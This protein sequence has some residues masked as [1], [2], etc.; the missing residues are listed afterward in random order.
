MVKYSIL[1]VRKVCFTKIGVFNEEL[2]RRNKEKA[3]H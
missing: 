2:F 1:K 3:R